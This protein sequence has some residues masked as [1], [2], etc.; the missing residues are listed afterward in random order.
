M[1]RPSTLPKIL[2]ALRAAENTRTRQIGLSQLDLQERTGLSPANICKWVKTLSDQHRIYIVSWKTDGCGGMNGG[3]FQARYLLGNEPDAPKPIPMTAA[4]TDRRYR[5]R[6]VQAGLIDDVRE[7]NAT[8]AR[9]KYWDRKGPRR[10]P[11]IAALFGPADVT[12]APVLVT[13]PSTHH[14]PADPAP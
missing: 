7:R 10:D 3:A 13:A 1:P 9:K 12:R 11:L 5:R 8:Y 14:Q 6:L 4:E 2:D